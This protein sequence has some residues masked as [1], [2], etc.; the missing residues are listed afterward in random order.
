MHRLHILTLLTWSAVIFLLLCF[1]LILASS[2]KALYPCPRYCYQYI[3]Y[4][5]HLLSTERVQS[6]VLRP[7]QSSSSTVLLGLAVWLPQSS[8]PS[9]AGAVDPV[10]ISVPMKGGFVFFQLS[11]WYPTFLFWPFVWQGTKDSDCLSHRSLLTDFKDTF[12]FLCG[13]SENINRSRAHLSPVFT[14]TANQ[15]LFLLLH[16]ACLYL[17]LT[18]ALHKTSPVPISQSQLPKSQKRK[19]GHPSHPSSGALSIR[20]ILGDSRN[21]VQLGNN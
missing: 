1:C 6:T 16:H 20:S 10:C 21:C 15:Q 17:P 7:T 4:N 19:V 5:A 3:S 18:S 11:I 13:C 2:L 12:Q 8:C 14:L 9:V